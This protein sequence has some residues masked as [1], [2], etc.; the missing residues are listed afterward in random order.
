MKK[1]LSAVLAIL[2]LI[3]VMPIGMLTAQASTPAE[4]VAWVENQGKTGSCV[5]NGQCTALVSEYWHKLGYETYCNSGYKYA[6]GQGAMPPGS[7]ML[8]YSSGMIP[9]RGDVAIWK[10]GY[11][12]G[13]YG[14]VAV[15][16]SASASNFTVAEQWG[17]TDHKCHITTHPYSVHSGY[18]IYGFIRHSFGT[19]SGSG[20]SGSASI[21]MS[22]DKSSVSLG[23]NN[24]T[25]TTIK[26]TCTGGEL[27]SF[28]YS[29]PSCVSVTNAGWNV[30]VCTL[31]ITAK[32]IGSGTIKITAKKGSSTVTK[33]ISVSVQ[34]ASL[35]ASSSS[36]TLN[37]DGTKSKTV[38]LT[39][40]GSLP[41]S[42]KLNA[43][44]SNGN[45]KTSWGSW[46]NKT[47][48]LTITGGTYGTTAITVSV[49]NS[50]N[51]AVLVA[52]TI[53]ATVTSNNY[54]ITFNANGGTGAPA[55]KTVKYGEIISMPEQKPTYNE[56]H[57]VTFDANGGT[58]ASGSK[59]EYNK[60]F[61]YWYD[62]AGNKYYAN[63]STYSFK[64]N[65]TLYAHYSYEKL[66][67]KDPSKNNAYFIG[68]YDS[69]ER[70]VYSG[71]T[72]NLYK[73]RNS[74][75]N[76]DITLYAMW[77]E[78][79]YIQ[80][81]DVD[82]DGFMNESDATFIRQ[83]TNNLSIFTDTQKF[84]ADLN[85][86][87][88]IT[89]EPTSG[90]YSP[91]G[92]EIYR[93]DSYI[94][95]ATRNG[96]ITYD[97]W[98]VVK[99][100]TGFTIKTYPKTSYE[101]G[102]EF[103]YNSIVLQSNYS[104]NAN[105]HHYISDDI[106]ISGYDPYKIGK[107]TITA[108]FYQWSVNFEVTVNAPDYN[109]TYDANGGYVGDQSKTVSLNNKIGTLATPSMDG[110]TFLGWYTAKN[111]GS[112]I[113]ADTILTEQ[114]D[115]KIY[116]HWQKNS[117]TVSYNANGGT[118]T[119]SEQNNIAYDSDY[120]I[121]DN[122]LTK[123]GCTFKGWSLNSDNGDAIHPGDTINVKEN[124]TLNAVFES[125]SELS[126]NDYKEDKLEFSNQ[127]K[128]YSFTPDKT[129][130]YIFCSF[131]GVELT[132]SLKAGNINTIINPETEEDGFIFIASLIAGKTYYLYVTGSDTSNYYGIC[133]N[134]KQQGVVFKAIKTVEATCIKEGYVQFKCDETG[135]TYKQSIS[136]KAHTVVVDKAVPATF[137][138]AGKTQGKHCSVCGKVIVAQKTIAKLGAPSL[139]SLTAGKKQF[140]AVWKSVKNI[141][142]YQI[143]YSTSS[144]FSSS[145]KTVTVSGYK[146]TSKT[147]KSLKAKKK[148][149][150][151][152]RAYKTINGKK[153]YSAW[154]KSKSVTTKK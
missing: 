117:F 61:D 80:F 115:V 63:G 9:Q 119:P 7:K 38:N 66:S 37:L 50:S 96:K 86:D 42:Y 12:G 124:I 21:G 88:M 141:D 82:L 17:T 108:H 78:S 23:M 89:G 103:D 91:T 116:A 49:I 51:N 67:A 101:Y 92:E 20:D 127:I 106:V 90:T 64:A 95:K 65:T 99:Y 142:G 100:C 62:S 73:T 72:G 24:N 41:S 87:G 43:K 132:P 104:N 34:G 118:G 16:T 13:S 77:S 5:G 154:S 59:T 68:W 53:N 52:T 58:L 8:V 135:E 10:K 74:V 60:V 4:V 69:I 94:I 138:K 1:V 114:N 126:E 120:T 109:L 110:Y 44:T 125:A 54:T 32:S 105:V 143:Q 153:Q 148:Y 40:G 57:Y 39:V 36:V 26:A 151:R 85:C 131:G 30:N 71:P 146:S 107:Q 137:K 81:G 70:D 76:K 22:L 28:T 93:Y 97:S 48:P 18:E 46:N 145:N 149:Y 122:I 129:A 15:V 147:V 19:V 3:S 47:I 35:S 31:K 134:K 79:G 83:N 150:V 133:V 45:V 130:D 112:K 136:K 14:H 33:N 75:I 11:N 128:V 29:A 111:G 152:I 56:K 113:T 98:P 144:A 25:S 27:D 6:A 102:E 84:L 139:S 140:K 55:S 121:P 123:S 2:M